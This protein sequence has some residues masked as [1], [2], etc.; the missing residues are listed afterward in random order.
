MAENQILALWT[1]LLVA[2]Y[3][4]SRVIA[5]LAQA[6]DAEFETIE[7]EVEAV[8][9]RK[10]A[11]R[12]RRPKT[13]EELLSELQL[14]PDVHALVNEI[15]CAY[16]NKS[17]LGELWRVRRFLDSRGVDADK[18]RSRAAALPTVIGVLGETPVGELR[19]IAAEAKERRKGDLAIIADQILGT[20]VADVDVPEHSRGIESAKRSPS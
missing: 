7:R 2:E 19:Q 9:Q 14:E 11:K 3:G 1:K 12:Q 13:L 6:E 15:G 17:Y 5:A 10:T 18:L 16:Q 4:K 20:D 8:R